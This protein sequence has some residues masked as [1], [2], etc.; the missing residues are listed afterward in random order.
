MQ[1]RDYECKVG[2]MYPDCDPRDVPDEGVVDAL[3]CQFPNLPH[4]MISA[5]VHFHNKNPHYLE[6]GQMGK[7]PPTGK[8][9]RIYKKEQEITHPFVVAEEWYGPT[10]EEHVPISQEEAIAMANDSNKS[11]VDSRAVCKPVAVDV[12]NIKEIVSNI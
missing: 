12:E 3:Q 2:G 11:K 8:Q 9:K 7:K 10:P 5:A 1:R 6:T 4:W